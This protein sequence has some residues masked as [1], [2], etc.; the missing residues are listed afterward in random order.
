[1]ASWRLNCAEEESDTEDND[2]E[3]NLVP[4]K[5][6]KRRYRKTQ[7]PDNDVVDML[8]AICREEFFAKTSWSL[9]LTRVLA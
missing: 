2:N 5:T 4:P 6:K 1:M 7:W 9:I 8:H 3:E